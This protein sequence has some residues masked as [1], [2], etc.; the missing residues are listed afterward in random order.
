MF[1]LFHPYPCL[2]ESTHRTQRTTLQACKCKSHDICKHNSPFNEAGFC[3]TSQSSMRCFMT[4]TC[5]FSN[6]GAV[7]GIRDVGESMS[8]RGIFCVSLTCSSIYWVRLST[9]V[10]LRPA[11]CSETGQKVSVTEIT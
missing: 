3:R 7:L 11:A 10:R 4:E 1:K 5:G 9:C 2:L 6:G 8:R